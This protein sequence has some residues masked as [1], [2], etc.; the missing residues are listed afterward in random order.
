MNEPDFEQQ[1]R[2][3]Q[4]CAPRR[5][6]E[7][8]IAAELAPIPTTAT[9]PP[10]RERSWFACILPALGWSGAGAAIALIAMS[11]L[12]RDQRAVPAVNGES[13]VPSVAITTPAE[14]EL[15]HELLD[16]ADGGIVEESD[17]G[18]ARV[19][20]YE[21]LERRRWVD[22]DGAI[23]VVEVPREDLVLVPVSF[24]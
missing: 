22:A 9:I 3:I 17:D 15:E 14:M 21:S 7:E 12:D 23:T 19:V 5:V 1:L 18:L 13:S 16:V 11:A 10:R 2:A 20:R 24:Q 6:V 4:P 8:R